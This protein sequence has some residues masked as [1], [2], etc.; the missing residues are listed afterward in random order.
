MDRN[1]VNVPYNL[2]K[3]I[4]FID[5]ENPLDEVHLDLYSHV[6]TCVLGRYFKI[7]EDNG[8]SCTV[9]PYSRDFI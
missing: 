5:I 8:E 3:N 9:N 6:Y 2:G 4:S 7:F 1:S